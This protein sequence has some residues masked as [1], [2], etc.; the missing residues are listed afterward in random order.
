MMSLTDFERSLLKALERI[1][2]RGKK[3]RTVP[4]LLTADVTV[5]LA[6]LVQCRSSHVPMDNPFLF[7]TNSQ[8]SHYRG[9]DVLRKYAGLSEASKPQLLT[10][11]NLRKHVASLAQVLSLQPHELD[12]IATFLGHDICV[13]LHAAGRYADSPCLE[14]VFGSRTRQTCRVFRNV[15]KRGKS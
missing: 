2:I 11:T 3:G 6:Q 9:A 12:S 14:S 8:Y 5:W 1:E 15:V 7:A 4:V 13:L 10:S